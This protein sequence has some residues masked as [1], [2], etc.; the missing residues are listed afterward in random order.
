MEN[1]WLKI[2]NIKS[3]T[4]CS[5]TEIHSYLKKKTAN[6]GEDERWKTYVWLRAVKRTMNKNGDEVKGER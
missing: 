3:M 2:E 1:T 5:K 4:E 6:K